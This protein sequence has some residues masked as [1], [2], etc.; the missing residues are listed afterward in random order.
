MPAQAHI[1]LVD[2]QAVNL[3][4]LKRK[5]ERAGMM[6]VGASNVTV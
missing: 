4:L 3:M 5:L 2:D 1:L 6:T